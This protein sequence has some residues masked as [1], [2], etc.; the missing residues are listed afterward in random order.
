MSIYIYIYIYDAELIKSDVDNI[1]TDL[2]INGDL[3]N[4][5]RDG[6]LQVQVGVD[7]NPWLTCDT[8]I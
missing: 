3:L 8:L 4:E 6:S 1:S 5:T 2:V 7:L